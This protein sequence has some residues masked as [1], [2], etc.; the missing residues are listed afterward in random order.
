DSIAVE[1][2]SI[3]PHGD[4]LGRFLGRHDED[5]SHLASQLTGSLEEE[6]G[7]ADTGLAAEQRDRTTD[8]STSEHPVELADA[9]RG[10]R[11]LV[12]SNVFERD[13]SRCRD[14]AGVPLRRSRDLLY[15]GL[16]DVTLRAEAHPFRRPIAAVLADE[17]HV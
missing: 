7:L 5:P 1:S 4:L 15:Q 9:D 10:A 3:G 6:G 2:Q 12:G 17:R 16:L 8:Q 11:R 14:L 13:R